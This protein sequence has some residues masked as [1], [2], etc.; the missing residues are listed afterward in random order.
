MLIDELSPTDYL[1]FLLI[2]VIGLSETT[3]NALI[4]EHGEPKVQEHA[5][6]CIWLM[7]RKRVHTPPAWL[8]ASLKYDWQPARDM[9]LDLT[10]QTLTFRIDE[11]TFM[12]YVNEQRRE[13][14]NSEI[15]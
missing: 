10:P 9:P 5:L 7:D 2:R 12:Q 13:K 1:A 11:Q 3:A 15:R 14:G 8:T 4:G 6:R